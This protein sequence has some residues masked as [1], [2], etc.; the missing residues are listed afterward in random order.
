MNG[1]DSAYPPTLAQAQYAKG[2]GYGWWGFYLPRLPNT[3]PLNGWTVDQVNVLRQAGIIPVPICVPAPPH[4]ADAAQ[5]ATAYVQLARQY[6]LNP[7]VSVCYNGSHI[8]ATGPVWLP[9]PGYQGPVGPLSAIQVG[10]TTLAGLSVDTSIAA[11]DFPY[12]TGLVCDLEFNVTYTAG[13]Y[14]TFQET[15]AQSAAPTPPKPGV[16]P[17][18][19]NK[20]PVPVTA[21]ATNQNGTRQDVFMVGEDGKVYQKWWDGVRWNG[22]VVVTD[23]I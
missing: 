21:I 15:V 5:T 14:Q 9:I 17:V 6:G 16:P 3:D 1:L 13:W 12:A 2:A 22:P 7:S 20:V 8:A 11:P 4:P 19:S 23:A 10:G 18:P